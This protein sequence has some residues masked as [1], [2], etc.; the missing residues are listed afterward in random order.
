VETTTTSRRRRRAGSLPYAGSAPWRCTGTGSATKRSETSLSRIS[1]KRRDGGTMRRRPPACPPSRP[2]NSFV[3][4]RPLF[5]SRA[6]MPNGRSSSGY[7]RGS[8]SEMTKLSTWTYTRYMPRL[9]GGIYDPNRTS[10]ELQLNTDMRIWLIGGRLAD[11]R[12][13]LRGRSADGSMD[14]PFTARKQPSG[15]FWRVHQRNQGS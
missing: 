8:P 13:T 9:S 10:F 12:Q 5:R 6:Q 7:S 4:S 1:P 3:A 2:S 11:G 14:S 15:W